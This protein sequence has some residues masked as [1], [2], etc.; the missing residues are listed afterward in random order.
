MKRESLQSRLAFILISA[1]CAIGIGN[2]WKFP[3]MV[4][5]YGGAI[6]ILIYLV[7]LFIMGVPVL[8]MEFSVGRAAQKSPILAFEELEP[9]NTKWHIHGWI[10]MIGMM[11]LM[12]FYTTVAGWML[13]YFVKMLKGDFVGA[14]TQMVSNIFDSMLA[15]PGQL[16]FFCW[17]II[18][19]ALFVNSMSLSKGLEKVSTFMM[20]FLIVLMIVLAFRSATIE[21]AL[22]GIKFYLVPNFQNL[23][24]NGVINVI[25]AA[26]NQAFF[27]LSIGIGSMAIFGS[28]IDKDRSLGGES[29]TVALLDTFV[30]IVAGFIIFPACFA[31]GVDPGAGPALIFVTLPNIFVQMT[32][33]RLWGTLFF[34]FM[35]FAAFSTVI[36]VCEAIV[37]CV[38][39]MWNLPRK[40]S[41]LIVMILLLI[42]SLPCALGFNVLSFI[43]PIK[44][45][46]GILDFEDFIVSNILLPLGS[47][48]FVLF[49][50]SKHGWGW[51]NYIKE[52]NT[53]RGFKIKNFFRI[54]FSVLIPFLVFVIFIAG[55]INILG[56]IGSY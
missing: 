17:I 39:D 50:T 23:L 47:M 29:I 12:M 32:A 51:N 34:L 5:Q 20:S 49:C 6:F 21:G 24:D 40:K 19:F 30:A 55:M 36:A 37:A 52:C 38:M 56:D 42:L 9:K 2:I 16:V 1:G 28:Y 46:F 18:I 44:E 27:T 11:I 48:V 26:M 53:G 35:T 7:F 14:D 10:C 15:S 8:T 3:W 43:H 45:S 31:F 54:Y 22:P 13:N 33:G 4:G 41:S 25:V